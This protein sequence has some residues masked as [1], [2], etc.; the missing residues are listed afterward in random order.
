[1]ASKLSTRGFVQTIE[2]GL[3]CNYLTQ[4]KKLAHGLVLRPLLL[5]VF[6]ILCTS[7][8]NC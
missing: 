8:C 5:C 6:G 3:T 4:W 2:N 1:M 7:D